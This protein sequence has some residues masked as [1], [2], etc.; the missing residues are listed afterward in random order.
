MCYN[1]RM[2]ERVVQREMRR[3][4]P[5]A[6]A[7]FFHRSGPAANAPSAG[8][9]GDGAQ[10]SSAASSSTVPGAPTVK[11]AA[12]RRPNSQARTPTLR[13]FRPGET[14][15]LAAVQKSEAHTHGFRDRSA[16]AGPRYAAL[17]PRQLQFSPAQLRL[18]QVNISEYK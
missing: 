17:T 11:W 8:R 6:C 15:G 14:S 2:N 5:A 13:L 18:V 1:R 10:P 3:E 16:N 4:T 9:R 12:G 7:S